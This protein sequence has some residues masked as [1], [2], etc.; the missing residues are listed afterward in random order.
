MSRTPPWDRLKELAEKK[1][2]AQAQRLG[3]LT[4]ER[5][6]A[7]QRLAMLVTYRT[8]YQS[9]LSEA[10]SQG[11][12]LTRLR[13]YQ[14]FLAQLERAIAQQT[15]VVAQA[16]RDVDGARAQWTHERQRVESFNA[17][18]ERHHTSAA[19]SEQRRAQKLTDEWAARNG[20]VARPAIP[21]TDH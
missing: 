2:D 20:A 6:E 21:D 5:D 15:D 12:D 16:D 11:I 4:R 17:L 7:R 8:E 10:S 3:A 1:R 18:D 9:R 14:A 13:N 19:R